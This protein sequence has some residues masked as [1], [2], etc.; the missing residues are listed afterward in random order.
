MSR[1]GQTYGG[2]GAALA[3]LFVILTLAAP[4]DAAFGIKKWEA[5][6]CTTN[7]PE[8][9]YASPDIQM[10]TQAA[11]H[12]PAGLTDFEVNTKPLLEGGGPEAPLKEVRVDLP[13][14]LN[15]DPQAVPQCP[16]ANF[17]ASPASCAAS[18][19][20]T[21]YVTAISAALPLQLPFPVYN[22]VP[23]PGTPAL[24]GFNV[25]F[26]LITDVDTYLVADVAWDSDYHEGF[27]INVDPGAPPLIRNR[28]VFDGTKGG[29]F[30]TVPSPCNGPTTTTLR[31]TS[32]GGATDSA[33]TTPPAAIDGCADVPFEPGVATAPGTDLVDS[34]A[35]VTATVTV[36]QG[37]QPLNSSTLR[38]ANVSLPIGLGLNPAAAESLESCTDAQFGKGT[39]NAV[40]CPDKSKIGTVSIQT[41]V[42]PADSLPGDVFLGQQLSRD[43]E[44]GNEFRV[45]VDA[46]SPR[47]GLSIRLVGNV[48]A[49]A[50]TG[51]LTATFKDAPQVAFSS[52]TLSFKGGDQ[53]PLT[54]PPTCGP[55]T[56]NGNIVPWSGNP[57]ATPASA[58]SLSK[59]PGGGPCAKT[60]AER[61]FA[62][63]FKAAP[64]TDKVKTFTN[65]AVQLG[66]PQG[67]QELKG[68]DIL[69]PPGATAKLKGVPYC[70]PG[71]I[72]DAAKR[73]GAAE[74]K[75]PSCSEKSLVGVAS[76]RA[77]TGN[78]P[79]KIDGKAYLAGP[80]Q[81]APLSLAVITPAVAGPFDLGNVVVRVA[82]NLKPETARIN[83]VAEI[84]DVFGGTKLDIRSIF[85]NVNRKNFT[86][87]GTNCRKGATAGTIFGGGADPLNPAAWAP[88]QVSDNAR[89]NGCRKLAYK[90]RLKLRLFGATVR[91]KHPKL[92]A[93]LRTRPGDANIKRA[94]V[95]LPHALFLDQAS[96]ATICTRV[97]FRADACPKKSIYGKARAF[98][99]LLGKPLEGPVYL[100]SSDNTLPDLVAHLEGQVDIDLVGRIDSFQGGIRTTFDRVP[101]VPVTKFVMTLPGGKHGL[102]VASTN[103]CKKPIR[104]VIQLKGQNGR[105]A[106]KHPIVRTPC[107]K[108][109]SPRK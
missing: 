35:P 1:R 80:Y 56:T 26:P 12:P 60:M 51:R 34:P 25:A 22:L 27:T 3:A 11:G 15:V 79:L 49:N 5:G 52:F 73:S 84:P 86:L 62:P 85:V 103:L 63:G 13:E 58:F 98:T 104:A 7:V 6:T 81:G 100:R 88:F 17:E 71:D 50:K 16:K 44:S 109:K 53:A 37:Q 105:K 93:A 10:F 18:E 96:L 68:V 87:T 107:N 76:V 42:L 59:A 69:L 72:A 45:F 9:T 19:V 23:D 28:L 101:D 31:L 29:T 90:P 70:K 75:A 24:F 46:E 78:K 94:S 43:P 54:S 102:L 38:T 77:G 55:N 41:P 65:F 8:C 47:Y 61:P 91:N 89:G 67:Q 20:G 82:L 108:K 95:A 57:P 14:G 32:T 92:R 2:I 97:Q 74:E 36:P 4:A 39:K 64:G 83:P 21:S 30:L 48:A 106:N 40:K 99:P 33:P 66:R